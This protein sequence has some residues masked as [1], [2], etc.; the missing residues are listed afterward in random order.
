LDSSVGLSSLE[1]LSED[2][3]CILTMSAL[4]R[5]LALLGLLNLDG[6]L[7]DLRNLTGNH[8]C[9]SLSSFL[10][11]VLNL[12]QGWLWF[13]LSLLEALSDRWIGIELLFEWDLEADWL[14]GC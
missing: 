5:R 14:W 11:L 2:F 9:F 6:S 3:N 8:L 13:L 1:F 7:L 12:L 4:H 10:E